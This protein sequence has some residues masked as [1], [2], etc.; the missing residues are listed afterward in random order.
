MPREFH[1][2]DLLRALACL[3]IFSYHCNTILPGEWKFLTYFG[4]DL[5]NNLF[6]MI[7][8]FTLFG[9][10][11]RSRLRDLPRW[12]LRRIRR[13]L[14]FLALAYVL[15]FLTGFYGFRD[16]AQV[17]AVFVYPTLYWFA[18]AILYFYLFL[19]LLGKC[20]AAFRWT[21]AAALF[22]IW[23]YRDGTMEGYY[24][25]GFLSML[26]GYLLRE[27]LLRESL[28]RESLPS[29]SPCGQVSREE[30]GACLP[31]LF[32]FSAAAYFAG[33]EFA[34]GMLPY[35]AAV[36]LQGLGI[37]GIG[38]SAL[39]AGY[40]K[41]AALGKAAGKFP[42]FAAFV[43]WVGRMALPVYLTQCFNGGMIGYR[44]GLA[45][46]FPRSYPLNFVIVWGIASVV[47]FAESFLER[48]VERFA[49]KHGRPGN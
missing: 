24:L 1:I 40:R 47:Y 45:V 3:F 33:K 34:D 2:V 8:G 4:A 15:S 46:P 12:F 9:S 32:C 17:F 5:G 42:G 43:R 21:A 31:S 11:S 28:L 38:L 36:L 14:P 20:P 27:L 18:S 19:F 6:F 29:E 39:A 16:P 49:G 37:L 48:F 10:I 7:S 35:R 30:E 26:A 25:I 41:N 44:I 13:I 22:G 23:L